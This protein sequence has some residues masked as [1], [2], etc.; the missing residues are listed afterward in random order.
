MNWSLNVDNFTFADRLRVAAFVLNRRNRLTMHTKVFEFEQEFEKFSES[1]ALFVSSGSTAN[2]LLVE[3]F[4]QLYKGPRVVIVPTTT[5]STSINPWIQAG[6][7]IRFC[8]V[9]DKDYSLDLKRL[10]EILAVEPNAVVFATSLIGLV[11][12][13]DALQS[14]CDAYKAKLFLDN[15]E[16]TLGTYKGKS[17]LSFATNTT[18][19]YFGHQI[20][21]IEGGF[22]F[23]KDFEFYMT[24]KM[25]RNHGLIRSLGQSP[26]E[27][28][29]RIQWVSEFPGVDTQFFFARI[30]SNFR[31]TEVNALFGLLD[32]KRRDAY[33]KHRRD[34]YQFFYQEIDHDKFIVPAIDDE[35]KEHVPFC[36][37]II[38][39]EK[40]DRDNLTKELADRKIEYRPIVGG[41]LL[42]QPI[43]APYA[44]NVENQNSRMLHNRG[45]Y[46]GLHHQVN[47]THV[48]ILTDIANNV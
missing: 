1:Y 35:D 39:R 3:T 20:C 10:E 45:L 47:P 14:L 25:I 32:F 13:L 26:A 16:N 42:A 29:E 27:L 40:N 19:T 2:T 7:R 21:S 34:M 46:V 31:N 15:C 33:K 6:Y 38:C 22:L 5:W 30:G 11:P 36:F 8:D 12:D 23:T 48:K 44:E 17:I 18:S 37:P 41:N 43:Y 9:N 24:A 4:K 28:R